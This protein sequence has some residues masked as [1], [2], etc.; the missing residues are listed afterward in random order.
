[1]GTLGER[2]MFNRR[3]FYWRLRTDCLGQYDLCRPRG[4][5]RAAGREGRAAAGERHRDLGA[6]AAGDACFVPL[7][8]GDRSGAR[9]PVFSEDRD[10][11]AGWEL[12][13]E[14]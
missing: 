5:R 13:D 1:M 9:G 11:A 7:N 4:V 12:R 6:V 10:E 8:S 3:I 2:L 14:V